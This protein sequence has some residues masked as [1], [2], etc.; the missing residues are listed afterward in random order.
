[1]VVGTVTEVEGRR[2]SKFGGSSLESNFFWLGA[3]AI[4][5]ERLGHAKNGQAQNGA[6]ATNARAA[7]STSATPHFTVAHY[8]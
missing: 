7:I 8:S 1:M 3:Q 4:V 5:G 2:R 6:Q